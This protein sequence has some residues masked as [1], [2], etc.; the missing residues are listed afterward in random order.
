MTI[1]VYN[2][3]SKLIKSF[4]HSDYL[5]G[6]Y[7]DIL[8]R[9]PE[10]TIERIQLGVEYLSCIDWY[11][12]LWRQQY[13]DGRP[14]I[15]FIEVF[16]KDKFIARYFVRSEQLVSVCSTEPNRDEC[17]LIRKQ[18]IS[19]KPILNWSAMLWSR[20]PQMIKL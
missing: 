18:I 17:T 12:M 15:S 3:K 13:K 4:E 16:D 19:N 14:I 9:H 7:T 8:I 11:V 5:T 6:I 10:Q 1:N 20:K 2:N